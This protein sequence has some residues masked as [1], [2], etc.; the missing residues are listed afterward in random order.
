[1]TTIHSKIR[2]ARKAAGLSQTELADA[3]G[4]SQKTISRIESGLDERINTIIPLLQAIAKMTGVSYQNLIGCR[5]PLSIK[6]VL[7]DPSTPKGLQDLAGDSALIDSLEISDEE[8]ARLASIHLGDP[9]SKS[10][11]VQLLIAI[12][13]V[14]G[15]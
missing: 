12:R 13:A 14:T 1:M 5:D 11:Y 3:V 6:S 9:V 7:S 10:G 4:V 2:Q 15:K 8:I